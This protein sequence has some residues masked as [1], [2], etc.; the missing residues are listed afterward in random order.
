MYVLQYN[1]S[2]VCVATTIGIVGG[3]PNLCFVTNTI[4]LQLQCLSLLTAADCR[5]WMVL[6]S[7]KLTTFSM[8]KIK[9]RSLKAYAFKVCHLHS[10]LK[11]C[12]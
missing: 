6:L 4:N 8:I 2:S 11:V 3:I 1:R 10:Y 9:R 7:E 5:A 12:S